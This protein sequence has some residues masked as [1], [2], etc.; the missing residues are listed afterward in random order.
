MKWEIMKKKVILIFL[1]DVVVLVHGVIAKWKTFIDFSDSKS[2]TEEDPTL[3]LRNPP[4]CEKRKHDKDHA[5]E[6]VQ[7]VSKVVV[8]EQLPSQPC[9]LC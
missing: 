1:S 6:T 2:E 7:K 5:W 8:R 9:L 4:I 3:S